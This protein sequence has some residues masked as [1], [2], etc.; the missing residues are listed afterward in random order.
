MWPRVH[1][2]ESPTNMN[3]CTNTWHLLVEHTVLVGFRFPPRRRSQLLLWLSTPSHMLPPPHALTGKTIL[4]VLVLILNPKALP[5]HQRD[6][7]RTSKHYKKNKHKKE[8]WLEILHKLSATY[9]RTHKCVSYN[10]K[11]CP[12]WQPCSLINTNISY[13]TMWTKGVLRL[14]SKAFGEHTVPFFEVSLN[15]PRLSSTFHQSFLFFF[16]KQSTTIRRKVPR[17]PANT[18]ILSLRSDLCLLCLPAIK[19]KRKIHNWDAGHPWSRATWREQR[20]RLCSATTTQDQ[21]E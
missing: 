10:M 20:R 6:L 1:P 3:K 7:K 5:W 18:L 4:P 16:F 17:N 11:I 19:K 12:L 8:T 15:V 14:C 21:T 13:K 2:C 9:S